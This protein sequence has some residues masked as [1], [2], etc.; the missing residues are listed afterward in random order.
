MDIEFII[1]VHL[2]LNRFLIV[3]TTSFDFEV[4]KQVFEIKCLLE[5]MKS[6]SQSEIT[7]C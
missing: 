7:S 3:I 6:P 4:G 5:N 1:N 2:S